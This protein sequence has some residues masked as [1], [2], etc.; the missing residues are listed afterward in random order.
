MD[1]NFNMTNISYT[2]LHQVVGSM[3]A[4]N[5]SPQQVS[6]TLSNMV[7]QASKVIGISLIAIIAALYRPAY[8]RYDVL[9]VGRKMS[10]LGQDD[11]ELVKYPGTYYC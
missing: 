9:G 1:F 3:T 2:L 4:V 11:C 5:I 7:G 10:V 6:P 8:R